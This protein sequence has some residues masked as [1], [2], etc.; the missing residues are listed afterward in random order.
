M[1][2]TEKLDID[3]SP[4]PEGKVAALRKARPTHDNSSSFELFTYTGV[5]TGRRNT[6][7]PLLTSTF[8][9]YHKHMERAEKRTQM[10][11]REKHA[12]DRENY[13]GLLQELTGPDWKKVLLSVTAVRDPKNKVE[14]EEKKR[15]T[16][17]ELELYL[18]RAQEAREREKQL[19]NRMKEMREDPGV[20]D[21]CE[22][23]D[24]VPGVRYQYKYVY[25][26]PEVKPKLEEPIEETALPLQSK[27]KA[28]EI[29]RE[30]L[31]RAKAIYEKKTIPIQ[32]FTSFFTGRQRQHRLTFD[33]LLK[34]S[35]RTAQAFGRPLPKMKRINFE[36]P[37]ELL[38]APKP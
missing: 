32:P 2:Y 6:P 3:T 9:A 24:S 10:S 22:E 7:D 15:R 19:K 36:L 12:S 4:G 5:S 38:P 13:K 34:K 1:E 35:S 26:L 28:N 18:S 14:L 27:R 17:N 31:K 20:D 21:F 11:E 8:D 25:D 23:E 30:A 33:E 16:V 37:A 29:K